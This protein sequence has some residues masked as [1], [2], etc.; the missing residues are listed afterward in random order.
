[1]FW[2]DDCWATK[3]DRDKAAASAPPSASVRNRAAEGE[4]RRQRQALFSDE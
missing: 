4:R 1:L 2:C 3:G